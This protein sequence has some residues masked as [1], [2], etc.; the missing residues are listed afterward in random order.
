MLT[1][2]TAIDIEEVYVD[3]GASPMICPA[4]ITASARGKHTVLATNSTVTSTPLVQLPD[5]VCNSNDEMLKIANA[6]IKKVLFHIFT[7]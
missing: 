2:L 7:M 4:S 5:G 6:Q 3:A 1:E